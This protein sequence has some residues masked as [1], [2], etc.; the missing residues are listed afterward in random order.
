M[1]AKERKVDMV[2]LGGDLFHYNKPSR[3]TLHGL[4]SAAVRANPPPQLTPHPLLQTR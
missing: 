1:T 3:K 2:L 4:S